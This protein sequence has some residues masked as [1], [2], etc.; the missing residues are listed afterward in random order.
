[1]RGIGVHLWKEW[2]EQRAVLLGIAGAIPVLT[3]ATFLGF[4][5]RADSLVGAGAIF[6]V[7][8]TVLAVLALSTELIAGESTRGTLGFLRR[9]PG[10][11]SQGLVAKLLLY[12]LG[13]GV[14]TGL[15][16]V[17]LLG[18]SRAIGGS[19]AFE[20][21]Y[22][23]LAL[24]SGPWMGS[25]AA[26]VLGLWVLLASTW[27]PRG[28]A[29]AGLAILT[30]GA[31]G[32]PGWILW[33][34]DRAFLLYVGV[35]FRAFL[36]GLAFV[37]ASTLSFCF[38]AGLRFQRGTWSA[39]WRGL[40]VVACLGISGYA[41]ASHVHAAWS[42]VDPHDPEARLSVLGVGPDGRFAFCSLYR[43]TESGG[44]GWRNIRVRLEDGTWEEVGPRGWSLH[45]TPGPWW[46]VAATASHEGYG[47]FLLHSSAN[48]VS[49]LGTEER[50]IDGVTGRELGS[51][52]AAKGVR[53]PLSRSTRSACPGAPAFPRLQT[54]TRPPSCVI[55]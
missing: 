50:L 37:A 54:S 45:P 30:L 24:D 44:S 27:V 8:A 47:L 12:V 4:T 32:F 6:V 15:G 26:S 5:T 35:S 11:L 17:S 16:A 10:G 31:L 28:A 18:A 43:E 41:Y 38:L 2:R 25:A 49:A 13:C 22:G 33:G 29:A 36:G 23:L 48:P 3:F 34:D 21:A 52:S 53:V 39:A 9:Q 51:D 42:N 14:A 55:V 40:V 46:D 20:V 1:M 7:G 19:K